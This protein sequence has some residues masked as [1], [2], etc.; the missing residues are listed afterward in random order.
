MISVCLR[1]SPFQRSAMAEPWKGDI[2]KHTLIIDGPTRLIRY[3][4]DKNDGTERLKGTAVTLYLA[5]GG[6]HNPLDPPSW[7]EI[8]DYITEICEELPYDIKLKHD[9]TEDGVI[10]RDEKPLSLRDR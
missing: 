9:A 1:M 8:K 2:R 3:A 10:P 6:K 5:R 7:S 4:V